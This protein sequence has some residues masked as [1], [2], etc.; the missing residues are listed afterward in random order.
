VRQPGD[1]DWTRYQKATGLPIRPRGQLELL[2]GGGGGYGPPEDRDIQ[3]VI[4]DV[5]LGYVT[6]EGARNDYGV[7]LQGESLEVDRA[8]T[9]R[10]RDDMHR[11][12]RANPGAGPGLGPRQL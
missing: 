6:V 10:L 7:A 1:N 3:R 8:A 12:R 4:E 2:S 11:K 9:E 5:R